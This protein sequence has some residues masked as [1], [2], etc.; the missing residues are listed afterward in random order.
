VTA[1]YSDGSV[2]DVTESCGLFSTNPKVAVVEN[3]LVTARWIGDARIS[4]DTKNVPDDVL[5]PA[6]VRVQ[7]DMGD[8]YYSK[9]P[10][11]P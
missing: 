3:G 11:R 1:L 8:A 5:V 10:S 6:P 4:I 2:Q 7:V 9:P